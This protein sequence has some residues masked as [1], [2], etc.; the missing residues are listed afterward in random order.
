M[1][2]LLING[3]GRE[4]GNTYLALAEVA[5]A[6]E[7]EGVET[8]IFHVGKGP[9]AGCYGCGKCRETGRCFMDDVVNQGI[10]K[11]AGADGFVFGTPVHYAAATGFLTAFLDRAFYAGKRHFVYKPG[12]AVAVCRRG[13]ASAAFDQINKYM[14][15][16]NMPLVSSQYWNSVHGRLPGEVVQDEEGM[17]TMRTL[18]RNMAWLLRCIQAGAAAGICRPEPEAPVST[19]FIR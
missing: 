11:A 2:V 18:G 12:A 1:K 14:T 9:L 19:S 5:G 10:E 7:R 16:S 13:G 17:Q 8:E 3:S 15:I 6:L 4:K